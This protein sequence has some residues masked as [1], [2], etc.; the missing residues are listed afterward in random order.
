MAP[1]HPKGFGDHWPYAVFHHTRCHHY[2]LGA[3]D[4]KLLLDGCFYTVTRQRLVHRFGRNARLCYTVFCLAAHERHKLAVVDCAVADSA[5]S[6]A[7]LNMGSDDC[8]QHDL[9]Q[10]LYGSNES[11][12]PRWWS[13]NYRHFRGVDSTH[14]QPIG[15]FA[16]ADTA[17]P[18]QI[19]ERSKGKGFL[20]TDHPANDQ[21]HASN[22]MQGHFA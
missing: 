11:G 14:R 17:D 5:I 1:K 2:D 16:F 21:F 4:Q 6:L 19:S 10:K 18:S 22:L 15:I 7:L 9:R 20:M 13:S 12:E 3:Y 8:A